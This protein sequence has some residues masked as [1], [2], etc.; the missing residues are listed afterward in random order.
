MPTPLAPEFDEYLEGPRVPDTTREFLRELLT[1]MCENHPELDTRIAWNQPMFTH[2]GSFIIGFS[3]S[4][5][6][7]SCAPE[8]PTLE[9]LRDEFSE[10]GYKCLKKTINFP[11][12]KPLPYDLVEK[13]ITEQMKLKKD[14]DTFWFHA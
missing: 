3:A 11:L 2:H 1:W 14:V 4:S 9:L 10:R 8:V 6:H 13:I 5:K 7:L 12:D